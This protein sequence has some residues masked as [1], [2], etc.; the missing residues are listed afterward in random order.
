MATCALHSGNG[1]Q[2]IIGFSKSA[3]A[4]VKLYGRERAKAMFDL[5]FQAWT[6]MLDMIEHSF[7]RLQ[8]Q[9]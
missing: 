2:L 4:L 6:L 8:A 7:D 3:A 5:A 1:G 9:G